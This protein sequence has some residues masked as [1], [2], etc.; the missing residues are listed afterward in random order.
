MVILPTSYIKIAFVVTS[1]SFSTINSVRRLLGI[2]GNSLVK[3]DAGKFPLAL[4]LIIFLFKNAG[5]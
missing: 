5:Q 3:M 2:T 1:D 4:P